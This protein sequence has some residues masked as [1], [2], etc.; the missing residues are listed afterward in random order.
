MYYNKGHGWGASTY[1]LLNRH[2]QC[3]KERRSLVSLTSADMTYLILHRRLEHTS[4]M[5]RSTSR[6]FCISSMLL[7]PASNATAPDNSPDL[8]IR[9]IFRVA[10]CQ[11]GTPGVLSGRSL[12]VDPDPWIS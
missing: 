7:L 8:H 10:G 2:L 3:A 1:N 12:E 9:T 5:A 11:T 6:I 4:C